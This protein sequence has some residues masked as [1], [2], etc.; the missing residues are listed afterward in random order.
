MN[1]TIKRFLATAL[2]ATMVMG[3]SMTS[4]AAGWQQNGTGWWYG[5]NAD[6]S[7]WYSNGW[8]WIDGKCYYFD[9]NGYMLTNTTTPDGYTVDASGAWVINGVVQ[10]QGT[11]TETN[12][13][14]PLAGMLDQLGLNDTG[15]EGWSDMNDNMINGPYLPSTGKYRYTNFGEASLS[16]FACALSG[17]PYHDYWNEVT[18]PVQI[19]AGFNGVSYAEAQQMV[20]IVRNFLN[21]FDWKNADDMTKASK[22][23]ELVTS[24]ASYGNAGA[25]YVSG[26]LLDHS[27]GC[28]HFAATY[29]LLTRLMGMDSLHVVKVGHEI[30]FVKINGT[31][32]EFDGSEHAMYHTNYVFR[33]INSY[34]FNA[35]TYPTAE[36]RA[37]LGIY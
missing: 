16:A 8:Q 3:T 28:N 22:A 14:Y 5:T 6:N 33:N 24:G 35:M 20:E 32:Y 29:H 1:K 13:I 36:M 34:N 37:V 11:G 4:F 31:W 25:G 7:T 17:T 12:T 30:N 9:G 10:T 18:D 23:A 27:G 15:V 2:A 21:S 26:I 19:I